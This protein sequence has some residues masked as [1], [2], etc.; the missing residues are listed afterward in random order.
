MRSVRSVAAQKISPAM[1]AALDSRHDHLV[2][3]PERIVELPLPMRYAVLAGLATGALGCAI[4]LVVWLN[5]HAQT[6]WAATFEIGIP[7]ALL[8]SILGPASGS[9]SVRLLVL[10]QRRSSNR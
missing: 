3:T 9:G 4:G 6:A 7:S 5:V 8:G 1:V 10:R 2:R